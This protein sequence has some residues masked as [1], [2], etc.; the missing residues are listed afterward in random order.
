MGISVSQ[1]EGAIRVIPLT[2]KI[3]KGTQSN[4]ERS[5]KET[6]VVQ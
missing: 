1:S 3:Y 4:R 2:K 6:I 5:A